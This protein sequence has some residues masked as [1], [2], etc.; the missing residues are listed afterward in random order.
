M[1]KVQVARQGAAAG[2]E[3]M[4]AQ[5]TEQVAAGRAAA[6]TDVARLEG[7][8][9]AAQQAAAADLERAAAHLVAQ[10]DEA[11]RAA[12]ARLGRVA[13]ELDAA[14]GAAVAA[15]AARVEDALAGQA[16]HVYGWKTPVQPT[17]NQM[18]CLLYYAYVRV[19]HVSHGKI[20]Y[21]KE[22]LSHKQHCSA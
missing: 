5:L 20:P 3:R 12:D 19:S 9:G 14:L 17:V 7:R 21:T 18:L 22:L 10:R 6:S 1:L 4:A 2:L 8:I 15:L 11:Q 16:S 13:A